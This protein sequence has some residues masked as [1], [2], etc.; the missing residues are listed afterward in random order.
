MVRVEAAP[1]VKVFWWLRCCLSLREYIMRLRLAFI[2]SSIASHSPEQPRVRLGGRRALSIAEPW[3]W[4]KSYPRDA[5]TMVAF[6][7]TTQ[8]PPRSQQSEKPHCRN[9]VFLIH[10]K[11]CARSIKR[12]DFK[13]LMWNEKGAWRSI[14]VTVCHRSRAHSVTQDW[15][16]LTAGGDPHRDCGF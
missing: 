4:D 3:A 1:V 12:G 6:Y 2:Q 13:R 9:K 14:N 10:G 5:G 16:Q 11:K 7:S 8:T 15:C